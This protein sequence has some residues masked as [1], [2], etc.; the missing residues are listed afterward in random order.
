MLEFR[1]DI[2][3]QH[4]NQSIEKILGAAEIGGGRGFAK[5]RPK[6]AELVRRVFNTAQPFLDPRPHPGGHRI[7]VEG[8]PQQ[9]RLILNFR[10]WCAGQKI[11]SA[12]I[13]IVVDASQRAARL[14]A[15]KATL[16][17][18]PPRFGIGHRQMP[19]RVS[20]KV[21][22]VD[23]TSRQGNLWRVIAVKIRS[24]RNFWRG[25]V[26]AAPETAGLPA[27]SALMRQ[28]G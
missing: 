20:S 27:E 21:F 28:L 25:A 24:H 7:R 5:G 16:H 14:L 12:I 11:E 18:R 4:L 6:T 9:S 10:E 8:S 19:Q 23:R 2:T 13:A 26:L 1:F 3:G 15:G 17:F 22:P